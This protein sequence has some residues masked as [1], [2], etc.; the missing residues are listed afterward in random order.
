MANFI[1]LKISNNNMGSNNMGSGLVFCIRSMNMRSLDF[2]G[3][4]NTRPDP[5]AP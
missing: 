3:M 5:T 4:Q 2:I 1:R